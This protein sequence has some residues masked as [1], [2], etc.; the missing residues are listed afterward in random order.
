MFLVFEDACYS[1][2]CQLFHGIMFPQS[3]ERSIAMSM[4]Q[5]AGPTAGQE[6]AQRWAMALVN[7]GVPNEKLGEG[8]QILSTIPRNGD[9]SSLADRAVEVAARIGTSRKI[10]A[11]QHQ[12]SRQL[13]D[14]G[15][16]CLYQGANTAKDVQRLTRQHKGQH[17]ELETI[18]WML[19]TLH[20]KRQVVSVRYHELVYVPVA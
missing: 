20:S 11:N 13:H 1:L 5:I 14:L 9:C 10:E 2:K 8:L 7:A 16:I 12:S 18:K 3:K 4:C 15:R 19:R 17:Y 6:I